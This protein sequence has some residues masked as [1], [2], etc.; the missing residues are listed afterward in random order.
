MGVR[1]EDLWRVSASAQ[2]H[3]PATVVPEALRTIVSSPFDSVLAV[4]GV[5]LGGFRSRRARRMPKG[6]QATPP[7]GVFVR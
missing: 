5:D 1:P 7:D 3:S 2:P 4:S 6:E